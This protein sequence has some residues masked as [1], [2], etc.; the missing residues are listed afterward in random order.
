MAHSA[1]A[2]AN[3]KYLVRFYT[4][5]AMIPIFLVLGGLFYTFWYL[6]P[7][8][9]NLRIYQQDIFRWNEAHMADQMS[10]LEFQYNIVP[11]GPKASTQ[12]LNFKD[13]PMAYEKD[14]IKLRDKFFYKQ[15]YHIK[16]QS[17]VNQNISD[18]TWEE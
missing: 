7:K 12:D 15:A 16:T 3:E 14:E 2:L 4:C 8:S 17:L 6:S 13:K 5:C 9:H 18:V 1:Q 10:L 11:A